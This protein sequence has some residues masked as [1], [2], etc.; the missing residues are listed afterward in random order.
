MQVLPRRKGDL[1]IETGWLVRNW[2]KR[3]V[4][5]KDHALEIHNYLPTGAADPQPEDILFLENVRIEAFSTDVR[6]NSFRMT[7][8]TG[9]VINF[10]A[11]SDRARKAWIQ[12]IE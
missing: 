5:L 7:L 9:R 10:S 11:E 6:P 2:E 3:Q 4:A 12:C 1:F 8:R